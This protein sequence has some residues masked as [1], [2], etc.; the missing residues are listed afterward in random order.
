MSEHDARLT[1]LEIRYTHQQ[2]L[3]ETLSDLIR[4]Q[5]RTIDRL[6][7]RVDDLELRAAPE[8]PG[9]ERPPHY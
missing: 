4:D 8:E 2:N 3:L 6:V 7:R 1:D 5:Q 9:N